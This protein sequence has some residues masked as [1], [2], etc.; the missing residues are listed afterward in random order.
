MPTPPGPVTG[1]GL[2]RR[3]PCRS[4]TARYGGRIAFVDRIAACNNADLSQYLPWRVAGSTVGGFVQ[5]DRWPTLAAAGNPFVD[6]RNGLELPGRDFDT[7]SARLEQTTARLVA[8]GILADRREAYPVVAQFGDPPLLRLDRGA[9]PFFGVRPFGVHLCAYVRRDRELL[10]WL[11]VRAA[12]QT[13]PGQWDNSVAGGQPIGLSVRANLQK[14]CAEEASIP[15]GLAERAVAV[16]TITYVRATPNGLAPD[17]L[18][19]F[20]LELPAEFEPQPR[21]GE[22]E[23]FLLLPLQEL[24][25]AVRDS[26]CCKPNCALVWIS[27]FLRHGALQSLSERARR[28]LRAQLSAP[29]P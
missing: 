21:D 26:D 12:R 14:E 10:V 9:V 16:D 7:R 2:P 24:V 11:A 1:P 13:F 27:F 19:C 22:V 25:E 29:L 17:T 18:F 8:D 15:A 28:Q 6:G 20:D 3:Y 4:A 23:R 5:R